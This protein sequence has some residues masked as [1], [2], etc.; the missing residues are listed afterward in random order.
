MARPMGQIEMNRCQPLLFVER[1]S[2]TSLKQLDKRLRAIPLHSGTQES[3]PELRLECHRVGHRRRCSLQFRTCQ[4][5]TPV[6]ASC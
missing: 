5:P 6:N 1:G 2:D 3:L 4:I